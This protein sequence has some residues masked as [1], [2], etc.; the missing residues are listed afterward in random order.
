MKETWRQVDPRKETLRV[1]RHPLN[2]DE[3]QETSLMD[4]GEGSGWANLDLL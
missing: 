2:Y 3:H 4:K 1:L